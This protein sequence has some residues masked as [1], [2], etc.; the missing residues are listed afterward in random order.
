MYRIN[1][2]SEEAVMSATVSWYQE[3]RI[4]YAKLVGILSKDEIDPANQSIAQFVREGQA[5][6]HLIVDASQLDKFP[7]DLKQFSGTKVYLREP[8]LG[9]LAIISKQSTFVRFFASIITQ[10]AHIEM[11]M[12]DTLDEG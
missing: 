1:K 10:A 8:N 4:V 6:V 2:Q 11:Q 5:P 12:F 3:G 7:L 9:K